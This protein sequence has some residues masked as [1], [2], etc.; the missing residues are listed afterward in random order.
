[1]AFYPTSIATDAGLYL[2]V[3]ELQTTL[4][5]SIGTSDTTIQ[6]TSATGFPVTGGVTINNAEVAFYTGISGNSLTGVTRGADGTTALAATMGVTVGAT[7]IAFHHNGLMHEIEAIETA[8]GT[9]LS[10][11]FPVPA[12]EISG[13]LAVA[14]GG[15]GTTT[16]TGSGSVVLST[17]PSLTTPNLDTPS[18]ITLTNATGLPLSTG[19]TGI[20]PVANGGS[21]DS[22]HTAYAVLAGGTTSTSPVQSVS[23]LGT[24]GQVLTSNGP[25]ALPTWQNAGNGTVTS[26]T[27][28]A[29]QI[30]VATGTTTPVISI[31]SSLILP[32]TLTVNAAAT[33]NKTSGTPVSI[34]AG[35]SNGTT[36][37]LLNMAAS[38]PAATVELQRT[39]SINS[40]SATAIYTATGSGNLVLVMIS[41]GTPRSF[42]LVLVLANVSVTPV[43]VSSIVSGSP[44]AR[45]YTESGGVLSVQLASGSGYVANC[46]GFSQDQG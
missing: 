14:N 7:I 41:D 44:P 26:V 46:F 3:N 5:V 18:A 36:Y 25:S 6:L 17:S 37:E 23:G 35:T 30:D 8:L 4:A 1:M 28:T 24:S 32:G 39:T 19:V 42:D 12:S 9:N 13:T 45:T 20:L 38:G 27:G 22:S 34:N 16:S 21:G 33:F 15:T 2:A 29:N 40:T 11:I 31:D 43:V 10:N